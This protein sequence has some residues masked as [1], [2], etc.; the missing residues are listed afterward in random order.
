MM[1]NREFRQRELQMM[2]AA[3]GFRVGVVVALFMDATRSQGMRSGMS[4]EHMIQVI[5][6]YEQARGLLSVD[7]RAEA[8][9]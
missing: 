1:K 3:G 6:D 7:P 5:L 4:S 9:S 2:V 8:T